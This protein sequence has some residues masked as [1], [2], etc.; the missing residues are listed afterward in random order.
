MT[1]LAAFACSLLF[2]G[3]DTNLVVLVLASLLLL[4]SVTVAPERTS[5]GESAAV[6]AIAILAVNYQWSVSKETSFPAAWVIAA[7]PIAFAACLRMGVDAAQRTA[8][9]LFVVSVL[10]AVLSVVRFFLYGER[11]HEPLIDPNNYAT[12]TYLL[13]IPFVHTLLVRAWN[14]NTGDHVALVRRIG[15]LVVSFVLLMAIFATRSRTASL[16][17][18]GALLVWIVLAAFRRLSLREPLTHSVVAVAALAAVLS[19]SPQVAMGG[20]VKSLGMGADIRL[21]LLHSSWQMY[22]DHPLTGI[23]LF[24]FG[25]MY[26]GYRDATEQLTAGLFVHNDYAQFLAEGGPLLVALPLLLAAFACR[27]TWQGWRAPLTDPRFAAMG[28]ALAL[29]AACAHALVNFVFFSLPLAI[30]LGVHA[31]S[32]YTSVGAPSALSTSLVVR[33]GTTAAIVFGWIAF[34][35]LLFDLATA[36]VLQGQPGVPFSEGIRADPSKQLRFSRLA[37]QVNADRGLPVLAEA[38][39][40][41]LMVDAGGAPPS[42]KQEVVT[43]F[44]EAIAADPW[45]TLCYVS[46]ADFVTRHRDGLAIS[47]GEEPEHLLMAAL[48]LNPIEVTAIDRLIALNDAA[49]RTGA[50]YTLLK[51]VVYPWIELLYR[52]DDGAADRYLSALTT[53]AQSY[54]DGPFSAE[55]IT[56]RTALGAITPEV[57]DRWFF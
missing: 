20:A 18:A 44:R 34:L 23:G 50:T 43:L 37:R 28:F 2:Y 22:A 15:E 52:N 57:Q 46:M 42:M 32:V 36:G 3:T 14:E 4:T 33:R 49:G 39:A 1:L 16:V 9:G 53:L 35:Y 38:S 51:N 30:V 17:V 55:L 48:A 10:L 31:A 47:A 24:C 7:L 21:D 56:K 29:G 13:W 26:G 12:L 27:G 11:A 41:A 45:N 8:R 25:L 5:L 6:A 54:G 40:L 19:V